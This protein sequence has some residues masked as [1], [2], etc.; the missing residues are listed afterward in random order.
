MRESRRRGA[1]LGASAALLLTVSGAVPAG[2]QDSECNDGQRRWLTVRNLQRDSILYFKMRPAYS[3]QEWGEDL[4]G[5]SATPSGETVYILGSSDG[6]QCSA[7]VEVTI[8]GIERPFVYR[9]VNYC[10]G[11]R[12]QNPLLIVD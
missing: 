8:S 9:N 3:S 11:P 4:L 10:S 2:A 1:A 12:S 5:S 7:D 6:C